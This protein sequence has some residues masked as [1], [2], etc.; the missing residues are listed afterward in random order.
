MGPVNVSDLSEFGLID[1]L[2]DAVG[3][4]RPESLIIGI[5]GDVAAWRLGDSYWRPRPSGVAVDCAD[6][7]NAPMDP[8]P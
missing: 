7:L 6:W 5:G 4:D 3:A 2:A 1:R 8:W